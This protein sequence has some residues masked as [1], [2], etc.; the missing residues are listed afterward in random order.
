MSTNNQ[1]FNVNYC[2]KSSNRTI[3]GNLISSNVTKGNG[4]IYARVVYFIHNDNDVFDN[5]FKVPQLN[6]PKCF[7]NLRTTSATLVY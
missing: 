6:A 1:I 2:Q 3:I 5:D 4:E 7:S